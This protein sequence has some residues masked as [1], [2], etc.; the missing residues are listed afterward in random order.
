MIYKKETKE[1]TQFVELG[2]FL[3][4]I[5][6]KKVYRRTKEGI[7]VNNSKEQKN[8]NYELLLQEGY[9][10]V[11]FYKHLKVLEAMGESYLHH[12][13]KTEPEEGFHGSEDKS[14]MLED[15]YGF[16]LPDGTF[17]INSSFI[18]NENLKRK[19]KRCPYTIMSACYAKG[20][21]ADAQPTILKANISEILE[22]LAS[23]FKK[24]KAEVKLRDGIAY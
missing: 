8:Y 6:D 18:E 1:E 20:K 11:D 19:D 7:W 24:D 2:G 3:F 4:A 14:Y 23:E 12:I 17:L 10:P 16:P 21:G 9:K 13:I 5:E 15:Y 22:G